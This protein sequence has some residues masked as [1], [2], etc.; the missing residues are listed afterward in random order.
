MALEILARF[1][2]DGSDFNRGAERVEREIRDIGDA[3]EREGRRV[4]NFGELVDRSGRRLR[5]AVSAYRAVGAAIA[6]VGASAVVAGVTRV[7]TASA[8][9]GDQI[10]NLSSAAG[11]GADEFQRFQRVFEFGGAGL[12]Q[13]SAGMVRLNRAISAAQAGSD[14]A[15]QALADLGIT[16]TDTGTA[17]RQA[18]A[19]V[20]PDNFQRLLPAIQQVFGDDAIRVFASTLQLSGQEV[21]Q[22]TSRMNVLTDEGV[23]GLSALNRE[24]DTMRREIQTALAVEVAEN[25]DE[26]AASVD[27][28]ATAFINAL[29]HVARFVEFTLDNEGFWRRLFFGVEESSDSTDTLERSLLAAGRA[30]NFTL[31][32]VRA[33][34]ELG[35]SPANSSTEELRA[36]LD[37]L[38]A[39]ESQLG[40]LRTTLSDVGEF[41]IPDLDIEP[42][43]FSEVD[44]D[45]TNF[46]NT[47]NAYAQAA[48]AAREESERLAATTGDVGDE[49]EDVGFQLDR[50]S[51]VLVSGFLRAT[52]QADSFLGALEDI[53]R[54]VASIAAEA[55]LLS[56]LGA[57][58][59]Q[60]S[61][62]DLFRG[63]LGFRQAGG[64]VVPGRP[65]VV[66]EQQPELFIP[67][68]P[69]RIEPDVATLSDGT[70][71]FILNVEAGVDEFG[72]R[73]VMNENV[74]NFYELLERYRLSGRAR[75]V[76]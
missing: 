44:I 26:I 47:M 4:R 66:G 29:P 5:G 32:E 21:D 8:E 39:S 46:N 36:A 16:A 51:L 72:V 52:Q 40:R 69:G 7:V 24:L 61:F 30:A 58:T 28:L 11:L 20:T 68:A 31:D 34:A 48:A 13:Y 22:L 70:I 25:A 60:G 55:A 37:R 45:L 54:R 63:L 65:Y 42:P 15:R 17:L 1:R 3:A 50:V 23:A 2:S 59:G 62:G 57:F 49:V 27:R 56:A 33:L 53:G 10:S 19:T 64:R 76:V 38:A 18:I 67:D 14:P 35:L 71:Q 43:D 12:E 9:L 74:G 41:G 73:R 75:R 6:A